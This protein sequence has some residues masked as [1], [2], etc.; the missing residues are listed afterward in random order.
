[1]I[2]TKQK[3]YEAGTKFAKFLARK[4]QKKKADS[5]IYK[6][7]DPDTKTL[8]FKREEIQTAFQKYYII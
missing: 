2:Y 1:M 3:Y 6:I 5:T 8:V 4:L 7:R